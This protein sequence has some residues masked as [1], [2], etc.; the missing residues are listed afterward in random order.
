VRTFDAD[1]S[2]DPHSKL[3]TSWATIRSAY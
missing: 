3:A 2:V 1:T